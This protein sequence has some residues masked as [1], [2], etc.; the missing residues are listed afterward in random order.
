MDIE[1]ERIAL[2][3]PLRKSIEEIIEENQEDLLSTLNS[4]PTSEFSNG[5]TIPKLKEEAPVEIQELLEVIK[6]NGELKEYFDSNPH[7]F[8][9]CPSCEL[10]FEIAEEDDGLPSYIN[11]K[12]LSDHHISHYQSSR[13]RC[14]GCSTEFCSKCKLTP[15]HLGRVCN[16]PPAPSCR[17]CKTVKNY[18][19]DEDRLADKLDNAFVCSNCTSPFQDICNKS[20]DLDCI[21][22]KNHTGSCISVNAEGSSD[23]CTI[24]FSEDLYTEPCIAMSSCSHVF[25]YNCFV[26]QIETG[27]NENTKRNRL[28]YSHC[29]C[30]VCKV[31]MVPAQNAIP[32]AFVDEKLKYV[33]LARRSVYQLQLD[34]FDLPAGE[35]EEQFSLRKFNFYKCFKCSSVYYGGR[36]ECGVDIDGIPASE[37]VCSGCRNAC[38]IH[39][40]EEAIF[41][42]RFCCS[43]AT[44][45]CF[46][47][48]HF[49]TPCHD[50]VW[51]FLDYGHN[52]QVM[53]A[54]IVI[55]DCLG[56][57]CPS[58]GNHPANGEEHLVGC[59]KCLEEIELNGGSKQKNNSGEREKLVVEKKIFSIKKG[60][61]EIEEM[62]QL[63]KKVEK[64]KNLQ[65][66]GVVDL[67][68]DPKIVNISR[69]KKSKRNVNRDGIF[70]IK[71]DKK[72]FLPK[73]EAK[74]IKVQKVEEEII[75]IEEVVEVEVKAEPIL[76]YQKKKG[77]IHICD[78]NVVNVGRNRYGKIG[79]RNGK[80]LC[81][82]VKWNNIPAFEESFLSYSP[83]CNSIN[84]ICSHCI[85]NL[86]ESQL[87]T[88]DEFFQNSINNNNNNNINNGG[89]KKKRNSNRNNKIAIKMEKSIADEKSFVISPFVARLLKSILAIFIVMII[90]FCFTLVK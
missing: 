15:Y 46:G 1:D 10:V 26:K 32:Q 74:K 71:I 45:F 66:D 87:I 31:P 9:T 62:K 35:S 72:E 30:G 67:G 51:N 58:G 65:F 29:L 37:F 22:H 7:L 42:C 18:K 61:K 12:E 73:P 39:D 79:S 21:L 25:H 88:F 5:S 52:Y 56:K 83:Q 19:N 60:E 54:E 34:K 82:V 20:K 49:C 90:T 13:F 59:Y 27:K 23:F 47:H 41:K 16:L 78:N 50:R 80:T 55:K 8:V 75:K 28:N 17:F 53:R 69:S 85:N 76:F 24:C 86:S 63:E 89:K 14:R 44:Y 3:F 70:H 64:A 40:S 81:N 57:D 2:N 4:N 68:F 43:L 33:D 84:N 77:N 36:Q 48:T 11:S 6:P 38:K